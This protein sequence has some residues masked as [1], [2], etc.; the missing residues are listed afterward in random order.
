[1]S[2]PELTASQHQPGKIVSEADAAPEFSAQTLPAGTAPK[3]STFTPNPDINNQKTYTNALNDLNGADSGSVHTGLGH[4][5][6][7][8]S[9]S[10]LRD[11]STHS[12]GSGGLAGLK[13]NHG[14]GNVASLKDDPTHAK[15]RNLNEPSAG[16]RGN[17]GGPAAEEREPE[18]AS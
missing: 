10:E 2:I 15:Q 3:E 14:Q 7:G 13:E 4:P 18:Q 6:Q 9:S 11:N 1:L 16:T 17:T 5:G 8:Q 12:G